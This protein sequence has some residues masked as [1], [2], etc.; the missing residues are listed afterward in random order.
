MFMSEH[1]T[2]T[3]AIAKGVARASG[4]SFRAS[5]PKPL[6]DEPLLAFVRQTA[7]PSPATK[8]GGTPNLTGVTPVPP[9]SP[10]NL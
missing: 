9:S 1:Y 3:A 10:A 4:L 8:S 7:T 2:W 5:R 6:A